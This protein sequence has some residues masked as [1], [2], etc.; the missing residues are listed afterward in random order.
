MKTVIRNQQVTGSSPVIDSLLESGTYH[1]FPK[2]GDFVLG[3]LH[4]RLRSETDLRL[5][6]GLV[7]SEILFNRNER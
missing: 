5:G 3:G 4:Q 7:T 6:F 1:G 2:L